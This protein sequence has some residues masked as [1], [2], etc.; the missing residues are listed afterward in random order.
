MTASCLGQASISTRAA[1]CSSGSASCTTSKAI[2]RNA[3]KYYLMF[4]ELW[5][6]ADEEL[7]PR[8]RAAEARLEEIVAER[9]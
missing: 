9:G 1:A 7:Q 4:V 6:G 5:A 3:S 8:V 2:S